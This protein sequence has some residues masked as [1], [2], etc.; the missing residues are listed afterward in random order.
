MPVQGV[1]RDHGQRPERQ[2]GG[3]AATAVDAPVVQVAPARR[4]P[5]REL[6]LGHLAALGEE[7]PV[8]PGERDRRRGDGAD[9]VHQFG[10]RQGSAGAHAVEDAGGLLLQQVDV[11]LRE[12]AH[13]DELDRVGRIA[14]DQHLAA[15]VDPVGPVREAVA[16][17]ART[18]DDGRPHD[19]GARAEALLDRAFRE[20][21][22]GAV[23]GPLALGEVPWPDRRI[24][25][26]DVGGEVGVD[27]PCRGEQ[28]LVGRV[29]E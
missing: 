16:A 13:V 5:E 23:S 28:V 24:L 25:V 18:D 20:H 17:V 4:L 3:D 27:G 2:P 12:V 9:A 6:L 10:G 14:L 29:A 15:G 26:H 8:D 19:Q 1:L 7:V 22:G 11:E 21:L